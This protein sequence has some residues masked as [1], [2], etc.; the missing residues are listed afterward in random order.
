MYYLVSTVCCSVTARGAFE[1]SLDY[2][3]HQPSSGFLRSFEEY[4]NFLLVGYYTYERAF[5]QARALLQYLTLVS[6]FFWDNTIVS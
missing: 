3:H 1:R 6:G 5:Q 4:P 2:A